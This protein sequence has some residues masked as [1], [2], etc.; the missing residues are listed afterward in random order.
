M[1]KNSL[2][3]EKPVASTQQYLDIAEIRDNVVVLRDGT[4]RA[5]LLVSSINFALKGEDEQNA[6]IYAYIN[7]LNSLNFTLQ[8]LI[9]SR[10]LN[11]DGYLTKLE[12]LEKEQTNELLRMQIAD[13]RA[14][15]KELLELG[16]IMT[17]KFYVIVPYSGLKEK[18]K[19]FWERLMEIFSVA[20]TIKLSE[21]RFIAYQEELQKRVDYIRSG[22]SSIELSSVQL[23]T[24][25]LI[26]LFYNTY[27]PE[28]AISEKMADVG[29]LKIEP[30]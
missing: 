23:G 12:N 5:V 7:F 17:K 25:G 14:F 1:P 2:A 26:E 28:V 24:Q 15:L 11:I 8:I 20:R 3:K 4:L 13:Y 9:Q 18:K 10:N 27:N 30:S 19:K 21:K 16:Q 29:K 22:L 6:L